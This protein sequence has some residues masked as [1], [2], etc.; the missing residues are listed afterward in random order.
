MYGI[1]GRAVQGN[2]LDPWQ[3]EVEPDDGRLSVW[4]GE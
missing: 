4:P 1:T 3:L 2:D